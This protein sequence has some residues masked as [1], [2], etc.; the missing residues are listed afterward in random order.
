[1]RRI[2]PLLPSL[3]L[4]LALSPPPILAQ[5]PA[6]EGSG[7]PAGESAAEPSGELF[8][9][10]V[11]VNVINVDVYVTDRQGEPVTGLTATDFEVFENGRQV[12]ISNFYSIQ[13]R[14]LVAA[15]T[16]APE[17]APAEAGSPEPLAEPAEQGLPEDQRLSLIVYVDNLNIR[18]HNRRRVLQDVRSFLRRELTR[19]DR[20]MLATFERA[21]HVRVPFTTDAERVVEALFEVD[22]LSGL[23]V[24]AESERR[25]VLRQI[26]DAQSGGEALMWAETY[27]ESVRNDL[28]FT[29]DALREIVSSLAG[30]PGRKA[31]LYVS[32]GVPMI[33]GEDVFY[34]VEQG[35]QNTGAL[36]RL[37]SFD[38]S[39]R[40]EELAAHANGNRVSFYTIDAAGLRVHSSADAQSFQAD[41]AGGASHIDSIR[42]RNLQTPLQMLAEHT[43]GT[44]II[45]Q[46]R[47]EKALER[48]AADFRNFY[49]LGYSP[50]HSGDG[51]YYRI[52]VRLKDRGK[53]WD[54]RHREGYRDKP[55]AAQMTD[56]VLA[57]LN[58]PH[59]SN[60]LDLELSFGEGQRREDGH[61]LVPVNLK[62]PIRSLTLI[63]RGEVYEANA[64]LY[65]AAMDDRG[66]ISEVQQTPLPVQVRRDDLDEALEK[67][68][69]YTVQILL[70]SGEQKVAVGVRDE[71]TASN[72]FVTRT[73]FLAA[74]R[75]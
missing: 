72:S 24:H 54:V 22:E 25:D 65:V 39:R 49:S 36:T 59:Y 17:E 70:R 12:T 66:W 67:E 38:S 62:I 33:A 27:A 26:E 57:A 73:V 1:M 64:S 46:N 56:G 30:L 43:G 37:Y 50:G 28:H 20:V 15:G 74:T 29:I 11:D 75:R 23:G 19:E 32:D 7:S 9:D 55:A 63:P 3:M 31:L 42:T 35:F 61:F 13:D 21:L 16:L 34:A 68:Y 48:V 8:I 6:A 18:P 51:R 5:E 53:G 10:R 14:K 58:F 45:N 69:V 60:P 41:R 4:A 2:L 47:V 44:A 71:V 40:F 52:E